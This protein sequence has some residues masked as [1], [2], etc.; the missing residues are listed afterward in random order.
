MWA[1]LHGYIMGLQI[2]Q[3]RILCFH[4]G[5]EDTPFTKAI[6][7]ALMTVAA[8]SLRLVVAL[9][10][11]GRAG[12]GRGRLAGDRAGLVDIHR[13]NGALRY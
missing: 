8:E 12:S 7:N 11:I 10:C 4:E 6:N 3:Q 13:D 1:C 5:P 9:L 2:I